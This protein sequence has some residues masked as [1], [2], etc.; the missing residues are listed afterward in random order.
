MIRRN[1]E[2]GILVTAVLFF[3]GSASD[4][5]VFFVIVVDAQRNAVNQ[6][7]AVVVLITKTEIIILFLKRIRIEQNQHLHCLQSKHNLID[8]GFHAAPAAA[9]DR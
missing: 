2:I 1:L 9:S 4:I 6:V 7:F 5:L 8:R 3:G